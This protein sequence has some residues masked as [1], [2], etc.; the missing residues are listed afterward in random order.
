MLVYLV[1]R[2]KSR[3]TD[4]PFQHMKTDTLESSTIND[5]RSMAVML[6]T[7]LYE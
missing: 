6:I 2:A 1:Q 4:T 5:G 3:S 7:V